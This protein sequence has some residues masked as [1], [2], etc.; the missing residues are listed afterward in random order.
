M[1]EYIPY[2]QLKKESVI[3]SVS[4]IKLLCILFSAHHWV[5]VMATALPGVLHRLTL[6]ELLLIVYLENR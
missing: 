2:L 6:P 1:V 3:P 5:C 4:Q